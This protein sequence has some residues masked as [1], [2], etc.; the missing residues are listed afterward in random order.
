MLKKINEIQLKMMNLHADL[1]PLSS[2][3]SSK[4]IVKGFLKNA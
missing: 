1:I 4:M 2:L 3:T